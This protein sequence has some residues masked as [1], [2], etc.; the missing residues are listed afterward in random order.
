MCGLEQQHGTM[1]TYLQYYVRLKMK[2][3]AAVMTN[4]FLMTW[5]RY[6]Q[7]FISS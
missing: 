4:D 5:K 1:N 3:K 7:I 2:I 6:L